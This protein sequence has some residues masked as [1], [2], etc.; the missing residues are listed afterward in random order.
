MDNVVSG[1]IKKGLEKRAGVKPKVMV[2]GSEKDDEKDNDH[3]QEI[4]DSNEEMYELPPPQAWRPNHGQAE[5]DEIECAPNMMMS[6]KMESMWG[7]SH[8]GTIVVLFEPWM[9]LSRC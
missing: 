8:S 4:E 5:N 3:M 9:V 6:L 2:V 1:L 7:K